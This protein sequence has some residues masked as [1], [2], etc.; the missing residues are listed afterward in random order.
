MTSGLPIIAS[1]IYMGAW[2][3]CAQVLLVRDFLVIFFGSELCL[4]IVLGGWLIGVSSGAAISGKIAEALSE[5]AN[6]LSCSIIIAL[7]A[8]VLPLQLIAI[9]QSRAWLHT[10][11]G[12]YIP[13]IP[14]MLFSLLLI[15][16]FSFL[17]GAIFPTACAA[18]GGGR[19]T[20]IGRI[21]IAEGAGSVAGGIVLTC[22]LY[23]SPSPRD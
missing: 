2:S 4:G 13:L 23:T 18:L 7:S 14:T 22:L 11:V 21:Y 12:E 15:A 6:R 8:F 17:V 16:P 20:D 9:R 10:P 5:R 3:L 1:I 19:T